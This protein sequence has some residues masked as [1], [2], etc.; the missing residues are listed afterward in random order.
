MK[1]S[2]WPRFALFLGEYGPVP[3]SPSY[4]QSTTFPQLCVSF[5]GGILDETLRMCHFKLA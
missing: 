4:Q 1:H 3:N 2:F 5:N